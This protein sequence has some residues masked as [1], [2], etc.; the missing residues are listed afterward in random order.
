V[1]GSG[2]GAGDGPKVYCTDATLCA[3]ESCL[4][5]TKSADQV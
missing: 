2:V 5:H 4:G 3:K 1:A